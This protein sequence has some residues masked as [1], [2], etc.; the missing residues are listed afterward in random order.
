MKF[1]KILAAILA[2]MMLMLCFTACDSG[3]GQSDDSSSNGDAANV[4]ISV[5][6]KVTDADGK[7]VYSTDKYQYSGKAP[8]VITL[9]DDY[10]F[11][12]HDTELSYDEYGTLTGIGSAECTD[13]T[14]AGD[15]GESTVLYHTY[16][17][18]KVNGTDGKDALD[19]YK[20]QDGDAIELYMGKKAA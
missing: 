3:D 5:S 4:S 12:E 18:Y 19:A 14:Q 11:M 15:N 16:W 9:L 6:I 10:L 13:I 20:V 2:A 7:T 8:T 17:W 1:T